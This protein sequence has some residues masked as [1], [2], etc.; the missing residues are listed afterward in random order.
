MHT[1]VKISFNN[2]YHVKLIDA[3]T[4]SV[5]QQGTFHNLTTDGIGRTFIGCNLDS[6]ATYDAIGS[7]GLLFQIAVGSGTTPPDA[8][9]TSLVSELWRAETTLQDFEWVD[10][11]TGRQTVSVTFPATDKYVGTVTEVGTY[12]GSTLYSGGSRSATTLSTRSLLTDSE[13]QQISFTKTNTDILTIT[14]TFELSLTSGSDDFEIFKHPYYV[15]SKLRKGVG[16]FQRFNAVYGSLNLCRYLYMLDNYDS[17]SQDLVT[18][19][20]AISSTSFS[21]GV[22]STR[23]GYISYPT[24]RLGTDTITSERYYK[25]IAIPGIGFW[26]LPNENVFPAYTITGISIGVGDGTTTDFTNPLCYFKKGSDKVYKNGV[27]LTKDIDYTINNIGNA[28]CLPEVAEFIPPARIHSDATSNST[29]TGWVPLFMPTTRYVR[30][31]GQRFINNANPLYIEY[32]EDATFNCLSCFGTWYAPSGTNGHNNVSASTIFYLDYSTD[33]V[34]YEE[35][36]QATYS[37]NFSIDFEK[38]TAKYWR[39]RTSSTSTIGM[40]P[41][42]SDDDYYMMLNLKDPYIV[43]TEAPAAG[44]VLTMDVDMDVI[45][46]NS[47]FVVDVGA[48]LDISW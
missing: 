1:P 3:S 46:K 25:G 30:G 19:D 17:T 34:T 18:I 44:D 35:V 38:T 4:G 13:G 32:E 16:G 6:T 45:M 2:T 15:Y 21:A 5:K 47:N 36:G 26:R 10:D 12:G 42:Y 27:Q 39:L 33:G 28:L 37:K 9:D 20:Q 23:T 8:S 24:I 11:Y 7:D 29:L 48:R 22:K 14:V 40:R 31:F 43:F 41:L